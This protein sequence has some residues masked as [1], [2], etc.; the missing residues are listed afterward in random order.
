MSKIT[1]LLSSLTLSSS[2]LIIT[3]LEAAFIND[4]IESEATQ[5]LT[6]PIKPR[7]IDTNDTTEENNARH[8]SLRIF[9]LKL[10]CILPHFFPIKKM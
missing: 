4:G 1:F 10:A 5:T 8:L 9:F 6:K 3:P 7:I 2:S